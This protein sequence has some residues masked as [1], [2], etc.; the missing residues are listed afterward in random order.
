MWVPPLPKIDF[1]AKRSAFGS[2]IYKLSFDSC[3]FVGADL[4]VST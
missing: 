4:I 3:R 2:N 1:V